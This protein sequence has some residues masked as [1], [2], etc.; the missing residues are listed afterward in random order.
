[1]S[2]SK[3]LKLINFLRNFFG[4]I[5]LIKYSLLTL[6]CVNPL[7]INKES[8][9]LYISKIYLIIRSTKIKYHGC[10]HTNCRNCLVY[11]KPTRAGGNKR[12]HLCWR[13]TSHDFH[14]EREHLEFKE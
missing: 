11:R 12:A 6:F 10:L 4:F 14:Q 5:G 8:Y 9:E 1:M 13:W 7:K 3:F 2:C